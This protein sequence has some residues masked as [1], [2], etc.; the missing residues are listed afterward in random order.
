MKQVMTLAELSA[1]FPTGPMDFEERW[2]LLQRHIDEQRALQ[3]WVPVPHDRGPAPTA[4]T[5]ARR[6]E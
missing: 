1:L 5:R 4:A 3:Y 6:V 2:E